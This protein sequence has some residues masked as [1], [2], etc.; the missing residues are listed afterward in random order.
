MTY[1]GVLQL[2]ERRRHARE[3]ESLEL[4]IQELR[5]QSPEPPRSPAWTQK[6]RCCLLRA[7]NTILKRD[8][9]DEGCKYAVLSLQ[10]GALECATRTELVT[11]FE[12][13]EVP[14]PDPSHTLLFIRTLCLELS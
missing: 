2:E 8:M 4:L 1:R 5:S 12:A 3:V 9:A 14:L 6:L 10:L 13:K 7:E 11:E